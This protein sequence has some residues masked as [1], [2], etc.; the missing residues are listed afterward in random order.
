M[1]ITAGKIQTK[2]TGNANPVTLGLLF[3]I[4][5]GI[6]FFAWGLPPLQ[7][8]HESASWPSV[9]GTIT[10]SEIDTWRREGK[11]YYQPNIVYTYEVEGKKYS[12]SKVTVGDPP[13]DTNMSPAKRVQNEY[14]SGKQVMVFYD[15]EAPSSAAL[16]PGIQKNDILLGFITGIFPL[17]GILLLFN[18]LK[19]KLIRQNYGYEKRREG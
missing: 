8:S 1:K 17:I 5:G 12:S 15:P 2:K 7:Y 4:F 6:V 13:S 11:T 18:G 14:P 9:Q 3:L 19:K 10:N 16:K